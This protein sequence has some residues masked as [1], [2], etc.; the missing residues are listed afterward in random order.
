MDDVLDLRGDE[1][2]VGKT[3]GTDLAGGK[4]TLPIIYWLRGMQPRQR[5]EA[6][7]RMASASDSK[8]RDDLVV[9]L[10]ES[11]AIDEAEAKARTIIA[12]AKDAVGFLRDDEM[13]EFFQRIADFVISREL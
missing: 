1:S 7:A 8:V 13:R 11:G 10:T 4:A 2:L 5:T 6:I 3:L 12:E 9:D